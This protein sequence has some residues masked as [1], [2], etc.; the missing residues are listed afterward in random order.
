MSERFGFRTIE[1]RKG[2]GV[3]LNGQK[4][5]LKGVNRHCFWPDSGRTLNRTISYE[6][7]RLIKAMNMN[8]V[9]MSHYP[10]DKHFLEACDELGLYVIDELTGWQSAYDT[11]AGRPLVSLLV[12]RDV[13][14][15]SILFWANGNEGGWNTELDGDYALYDPQK[16]AVLHPWALFG[17]IDTAHYREYALHLKL[18]NEAPDLYMPTEFLHALYDGGAGAGLNDYWKAIKNSPRGAGGFIWVLAD[19]GVVRTDRGGRFDNDGNHA[20]DGIVG[21]CRQKEGSFYTVKEIW[22]PVQ[23]LL[24]TLNA[25]FDGVIPVENDYAFTNQIGRAHV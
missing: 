16:R 8:A 18:L 3:Y 1:V 17:D 11:K 4:I 24:D 13:N 20:P 6:D 15:P 22:S 14:H 10:P 9:R 23:V 25:S 7:A 5:R 12:K 2:D 19:E 21:P